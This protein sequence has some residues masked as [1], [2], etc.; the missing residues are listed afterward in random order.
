[1]NHVLV[2]H[3]HIQIIAMKKIT[4]EFQ[5]EGIQKNTAQNPVSIIKTAKQDDFF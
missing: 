3:N 4:I 2:R 1:M 5:K